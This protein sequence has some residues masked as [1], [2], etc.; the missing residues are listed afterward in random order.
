M[1]TICLIR[2]GATS[3]N[4]QFL[5]CGVTYLPLSEAGAAALKEK[6]ERGGYPDISGFRVV[7]SGLRRTEETLRLLFGE[8]PHETEPRLREISFGIYEMKSYYQLEKDGTFLRWLE[9]SDTTAP[10]GGESGQEMRA[11]VLEGFCALAERGEDT[12]AVCHG[13]PIAAIMQQLFPEEGKNRYEWQPTGGE[14]YEL[15]M[16]GGKA[17]SYRKIPETPA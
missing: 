8:V 10:E 11:R 16:D 7:T 17:L 13:G 1:N 9:Q 5:Y 6:R 12:L 14:G 15:R 2:H 4:E 3:A